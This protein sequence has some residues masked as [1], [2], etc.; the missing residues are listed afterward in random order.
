MVTIDTLPEDV[1][2]SVVS[3]VSNNPRTERGIV[4]YPVT[5]TVDVPGG[6]EIPVRLSGVSVVISLNEKEIL[7][8]PHGAVGGSD[9]R[10]VA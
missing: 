3:L 6:T 10:P 7:L 4:S 2:T 5:I 8:A 1:F 9:W